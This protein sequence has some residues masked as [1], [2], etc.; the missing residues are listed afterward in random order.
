MGTRS[1]QV[2]I[3]LG[4]ARLR[5]RDQRQA[6]SAPH[7]AIVDEEGS[8]RAW[9]DEALAMAGRL[10]PRLRLV[11]PVAAGAVADLPLAARLLGSA[12]RAASGK[13]RRL[14]GAQAV[15]C[16][17]DHATSLER[18]VLRQVCKDAG[19]NQVRSVPHSVAAAV[20]AGVSGSPAGALLVDIG[21]HRTSASMIA[22]GTA[23]VTRTVKRGAGSVDTWLMRHAREE[24]ALTIGARVAEE[25]KL[26][27]ALETGARLPV[28][29]QDRDEGLPRV[30]EL[31]VAEIRT[32]LR[33]V[34][35]DVARLVTA[36][37]DA[38]PPE[39]VDDVFERGVLLHGGGA[40]L[41][42]L[43]AHLRQELSM[44]VHLVESGADTAVE[45]AWLLAA[46][47]PVLELA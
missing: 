8:L 41:Y 31:T 38:S 44:P 18:H 34:Y 22:L 30:G 23:L 42:G 35:E 14:R 3:D 37:L 6:W 36:V 39:L 32:V 47:G 27:A 24:H 7:V 17:P 12:L 1:R 11:R 40:R 9:G 26:A 20:G 4:S 28:R 43:D 21:E 46:E 45:G 33:P 13:S 10:P 29:G 5:L 25:A 15:V 19:I 2:A 16:V